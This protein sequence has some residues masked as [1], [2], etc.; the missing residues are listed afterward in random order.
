MFT[1]ENLINLISKKFSISFE[2]AGKE[3]GNYE[4]FKELKKI[5][6]K[7]KLTARIPAIFGLFGCINYSAVCKK[8]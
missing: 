1:L 3:V 2:E 8:L 7:Q 5:R 6:Q 4:N